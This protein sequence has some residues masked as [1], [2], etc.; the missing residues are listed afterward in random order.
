M[1]TSLNVLSHKGFFENLHPDFKALTK[2][3]IW[4]IFKNYRL[5]ALDDFIRSAYPV[6]RTP[7]HMFFMI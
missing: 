7:A 6:E 2:D 3:Q 5:R 4:V 1:V